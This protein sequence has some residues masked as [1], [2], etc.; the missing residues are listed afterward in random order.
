MSIEW[1]SASAAN[2]LA[3][4]CSPAICSSLALSKDCC[5]ASAKSH[6]CTV[7][8]KIVCVAGR[9]QAKGNNFATVAR[10]AHAARIVAIQ[11]LHR[12]PWKIRAL[13]SAYASMSA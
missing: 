13:A 4:L 7:N 5:R 1:H 6:L 3:T 2:A 8:A 9:I 12:L 10:H 11:Y